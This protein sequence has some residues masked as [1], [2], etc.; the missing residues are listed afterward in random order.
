MKPLGLWADPT[1][2][3]SL[4]HVFE[5]LS[6]WA[7][8]AGGRCFLQC[9]EWHRSAGQAEDLNEPSP[10][11]LLF[12]DTRHRSALIAYRSWRHTHTYTLAHACIHT[13]RWTK[14]KH[15]SSTRPAGGTYQMRFVSKR[16]PMAVWGVWLRSTHGAVGLWRFSFFV[17]LLFIFSVSGSWSN[18][19]K[20]SHGLLSL[21]TF[22]PVILFFCVHRTIPISADVSTASK[23]AC[24]LLKVLANVL[25][26]G[27]TT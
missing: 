18:G 22:T 13:T 16:A 21:L 2:F 3:N 26:V 15:S 27:I 5:Q 14:N 1:H 12:F 6:P 23:T 4:S 8:N 9:A 7:L 20:Q 25:F 11:L 24:W 17:F 10:F 19:N